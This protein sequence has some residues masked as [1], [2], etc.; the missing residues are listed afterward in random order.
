MN[1]KKK[2]EIGQLILYNPVNSIRFLL[3]FI[4]QFVL[5]LRQSV[6]L[7]DDKP[8]NRLPKKKF[9]IRN[10]DPESADF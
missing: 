10:P 5:L 9:R 8:R 6:I 1:E 7:L 3:H 2:E 4:M